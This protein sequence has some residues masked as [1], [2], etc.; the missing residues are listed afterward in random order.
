V[1]AAELSRI[2]QEHLPIPHVERVSSVLAPL[3]G[4]LGYQRAQHGQ[5]SDALT[6]DANYVRRTDAEVYAKRP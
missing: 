6:L 4:Q 2:E 3:I 1:F 5:V